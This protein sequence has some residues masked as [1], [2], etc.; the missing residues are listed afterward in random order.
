MGT[1]FL[2]LILAVALFAPPILLSKREEKLS[3]GMRHLLSIIPFGYT[4]IG[5]KLGAFGYDYFGCQ[6]NPKSFHDCIGWGID[7]T[8]LIG[9]G[10][11]LMLP[12]VFFALPISLWLSLNTAAKQFRAWHK[13]NYPNQTSHS[14]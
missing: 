14:K 3:W 9:Y 10:L 6:G 7:L 1:S 4:L 8:S 5:W 11:F 13:K 12:C 2:L